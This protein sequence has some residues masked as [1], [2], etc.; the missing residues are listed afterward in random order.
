MAIPPDPW[1]PLADV[2][3]TPPGRLETH[4]QLEAS[5]EWFSGHFEDCPLVPGVAILAFAVEAVRRQGNREGRNLEVAAFS[6]VRFKR[7]VYPDEKLHIAV[8]PMPLQPEAAL[9]F[10]ITVE[11]NDVAQ[12]FLQMK[13]TGDLGVP[14]K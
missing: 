4:V 9:R 1:L 7:F 10:H 2:R 12:G 14:G 11:G 3:V 8:D 6:R 5:S 13:E